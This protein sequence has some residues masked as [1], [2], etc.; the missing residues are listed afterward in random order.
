[1]ALRGSPELRARLRALKLAFKPI[2]KAWATET[3][4]QD[5]RRVPVKTGRLQRSIRVRNAS[6][7][8]ATVVAH[9][10]ASFI[11]VGTKEHDIVPKKA[12]SLK[13]QVQGRTIFSKKVHKPRQ[14]ARPF[15][16]AGAIEALRKTPMA[17]TIVNEW[18]RAAR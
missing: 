4:A 2:G 16:K 8:K 3:V 9:Y 1:M 5:R 10:T 12:S 7:R 13:F 15:E 14:A 17:A 6:Q 18:N 11:D